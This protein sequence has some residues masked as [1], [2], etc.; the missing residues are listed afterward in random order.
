MR[1]EAS[2]QQAPSLLVFVLFISERALVR[3]SGFPNIHVEVGWRCVETASSA[4]NR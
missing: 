4:P 3:T 2:A 1:E